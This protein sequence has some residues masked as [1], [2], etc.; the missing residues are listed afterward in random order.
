MSTQA[1]REEGTFVNISF[2]ID[3]D[4]K[5]TPTNTK[6]NC[7][8][9]TRASFKRSRP[10]ET[11]YKVRFENNFQ[12]QKGQKWCPSLTNSCDTIGGNINTVNKQ[13]N[14][15]DTTTIPQKISE[16]QPNIQT[17]FSIKQFKRVF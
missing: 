4:I 17:T 1:K 7:C 10:K 2:M 6:K 14:G 11:E 15:N 9:R 8:Y 5:S 16:N 12:N 3:R 13:Q